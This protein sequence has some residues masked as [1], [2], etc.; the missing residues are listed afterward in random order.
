MAVVFCPI[1]VFLVHTH[2]C[3]LWLIL[4]ISAFMPR[5]EEGGLG[6]ALLLRKKVQRVGF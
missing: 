3:V 1:V 2:A 4:I 5:E 6:I